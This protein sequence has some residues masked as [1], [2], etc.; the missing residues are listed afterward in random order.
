[1]FSLYC[2]CFFCDALV[3]IEFL[4]LPCANKDMM[5]MMMMMMIVFGVNAMASGI[6]I[7]S[8][9]LMS[10]IRISDITI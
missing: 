1:M 9:L 8:Q 2:V 6:D 4:L 10:T 3:F 7:Y 5:I